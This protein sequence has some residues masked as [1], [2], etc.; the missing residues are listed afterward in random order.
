MNFQP[1]ITRKELAAKAGFS[2]DTLTR[3]YGEKLEAARCQAVEKP[4]TYFATRATSIL[5]RA[6]AVATEN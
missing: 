4:V 2:V 1:T 5:I 3:K 6:G